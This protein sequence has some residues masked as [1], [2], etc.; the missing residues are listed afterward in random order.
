MIEIIQHLLLSNNCVIVPGLGAFVGNYNHAEIQLQQHQ[1]VPPSKNIAFNRSLQNNDGLLMNEVAVQQHVSLNQAEELIHAF[2]HQVNT[3]LQQNKSFVFKEIGRLFLDEKEQIRFQPY[4]SKNF[5]MDSY[6][7]PT[8]SIAP[9]QRL[10][11]DTSIIQQSYQRTLSNL[12]ENTISSKSNKKKFIVA[13]TIAA[14]ILLLIG[15]TFFLNQYSIKPFQSESSLIPVF[16]SAPKSVTVQN[17]IE[18]INPNST[19]N[20][21][22]DTFVANATV[23]TITT[24]ESS[25]LIVIGTFF[26]STLANKLKTETEK[27]GYAVFIYKDNQNGLFRTTVQVKTS[28]VATQLNTIKTE[29]NQRAWIYCVQCNL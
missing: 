29:L 6:G 27:K 2:V 9:I 22:K 25:S 23:P 18:V 13:T 8:L 26:D 19:I 5:L 24:T 21:T 17:K 1:I 14:T 16:D 3:S 4:Y 15:T 20:Q 10:K 12:G 7:L 28:D 11:T